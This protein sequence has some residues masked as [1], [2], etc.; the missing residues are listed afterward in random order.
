MNNKQLLLHKALIMF[1]E[2]GYDAVGVQEICI[3]CGITKPTLYH[4]FA[5]KKKLLESILETNYPPLLQQIEQDA[6]HT[7][8]LTLN[9]EQIAN[10]FFDFTIKNEAFMRFILTISFSPVGSDTFCA[11][12]VYSAKLY[13]IMEQLF[14]SS[15]PL[16]GNLR[17]KEKLLSASF[18]GQIHTFSA[19]YLAKEV[20]L[21]MSF[22]Q[23]VVKQFMHGI[24]S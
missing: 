18:I 4:Y 22:A 5:S 13:A 17:N 8:D 19:F 3:E 14:V 21:N 6:N 16:H 23:K 2:R 10:T 9:L 20:S 1:S 15:V 7:S 12:R 24:Y 11:H